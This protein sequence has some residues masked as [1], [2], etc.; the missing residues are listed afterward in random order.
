MANE[1]IITAEQEMKLR[2]PFEDY[3]GKIQ[4]KIDGLRV[5]GTDKVLSLQ[6]DIDA[7]KR[8][9]VLTKGEKETAISEKRVL[10][11]KA[12]GIEEKT[13]GKLQS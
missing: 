7:I 10:L 3:V 2:K 12:K 6:N 5:E 9:R 1:N 13:K 8:D 4:K 11:E